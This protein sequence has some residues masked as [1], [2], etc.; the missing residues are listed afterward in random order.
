MKKQKSERIIFLKGNKIILRPICKETDLPTLLRW[1]N[2]PEVIQYLTTYLPSMKQ[3]E[4][5]WLD[6]LP[7]N[8]N[9]NIVLAIETLAGKFIGVMGLHR[10]DWK[11]RTAGTG[12]FIGNKKYWNRGYGTDAKMILLNYAF[13]T[14]NLRK[15]YSGAIAFNKRSIR[16][17]LHCGYKIEGRRRKHFFVQGRYYDEVI[18]AVFKPDWLPIWKKFKATVRI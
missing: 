6:S 11:N 9:E 16:Y 13:N 4:E 7:K 18:L 15:I 10:I 1:I 12:A 3:N 17:S 5:E 2:D 8:R 14:L